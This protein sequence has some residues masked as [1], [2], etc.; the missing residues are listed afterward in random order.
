M[1]IKDE[2]PQMV[3]MLKITSILSGVLASLKTC[4][5]FESL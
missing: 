5:H 2:L 4:R 3:G 1:A